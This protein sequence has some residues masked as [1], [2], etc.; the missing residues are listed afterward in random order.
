M[1]CCAYHTFTDRKYDFVTLAAEVFFRLLD[2]P[3]LN[4]LRQ[5]DFEL[6]GSLIHFWE[7][8]V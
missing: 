3:F 4:I 2:K 8:F 5:V 6:V 7:L 1:V